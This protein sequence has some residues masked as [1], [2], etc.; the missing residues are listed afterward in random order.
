MKISSS[1]PK[2]KE[3]LKEFIKSSFSPKEDK[4]YNIL[5]SLLQIIQTK[6]SILETLDSFI[7]SLAPIIFAYHLTHL[8]YSTVLLS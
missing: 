6:I 4:F 5:F 8:T 3:R 2:I 1:S 7:P